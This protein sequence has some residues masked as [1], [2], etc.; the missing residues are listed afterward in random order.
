MPIVEWTDA[1]G[2]RH[3]KEADQ[4]QD[5]GRGHVVVYWPK[6]GSCHFHPD[7]DVAVDGV[8]LKAPPSTSKIELS[9]PVRESAIDAD[10][11]LKK[12]GIKVRYLATLMNSA[13]EIHTVN[14]IDVSGYVE[15][16]RDWKI[17]KVIK[18]V[19]GGSVGF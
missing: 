1:S 2:T 10:Y 9:R 7:D 11:M 8:S 3:K 14:I 16:C 15:N 6:G 12:K 18:K 13:G 19:E 4:I 17:V 5:L